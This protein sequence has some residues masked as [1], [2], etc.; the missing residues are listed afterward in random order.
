MKKAMGNTYSS[1][2]L[3]LFLMFCLLIRTGNGLSS[4]HV[5]LFD[6]YETVRGPHLASIVHQLVERSC[7]GKRPRISWCSNFQK[8]TRNDQEAAISTIKDD[9]ACEALEIFDLSGYRPSRLHD[10]LSELN[11]NIVWVSDMGSV[12]Q[13]VYS[14]RT[15]GLDKWID[16][17]CGGF[18]KESV[19]YVGEAN[20]AI[21]AGS[22]IRS[23]AE[24]RGDSPAR[25][26]QFRGLEL[27]GPKNSF[28]FGKSL[29]LI[30]N[31]KVKQIDPEKVFV[32][33]QL[34]EDDSICFQMCPTEFGAIEGIKYPK[35]LPPLIDQEGVSCI[36]EPSIDPSRTLQATDD[37]GWME[38]NLQDEGGDDSDDDS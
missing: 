34:L 28:Y 38:D 14:M 12:L 9:L 24:A 21:A 5:V 25:E 17:N 6:R 1:K 29:N 2:A 19:L 13:L 30:D 31:K 35:L 11:P 7:L 16:R 27:L 33:S 15:S 8:E 18:G 23:V 3:V 36:G 32:W 20:G 22:D 4:R 26:L 37:S 10:E